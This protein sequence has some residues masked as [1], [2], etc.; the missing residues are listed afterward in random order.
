ML[1]V[2]IYQ[3]QDLFNLIFNKTVMAISVILGS[4]LTAIGY[5]KEVLAFILVLII[6]DIATKQYSIVKKE[7]KNYTIKNYFKA[8]K[9]RKLTSRALKNGIGVKTLLY[10]PILYVAHT[11]CRLEEIVFGDVIANTLYTLLV[12]IEASSIIENFTD[13]GY[14]Q[15]IPFLKYLRSKEE[16]LT[17]SDD[18][19]E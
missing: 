14:T 7:Y 19:V 1:S 15:L 2:I 4:L 10:L 12:V 8:W 18:I 9:E 5:P 17:K 3:A 16:S 13:C 11:A 6:I